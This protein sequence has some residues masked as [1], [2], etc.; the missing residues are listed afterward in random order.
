MDAAERAEFADMVAQAVIDRLEERRQVNALVEMVL[1]RMAVLQEE[2][3]AAAAANAASNTARP[4]SQ[5]GE[6]S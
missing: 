1:H 5:E 6:P 2:E 3:K 4:D